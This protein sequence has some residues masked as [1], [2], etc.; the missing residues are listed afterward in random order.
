MH[1][2]FDFHMEHVQE[3]R[4]ESGLEGNGNALGPSNIGLSDQ[5]LL[6][7][8]RFGLEGLEEETRT[9]EQVSN[10]GVDRQMEE[11]VHPGANN[12]G[13]P[14]LVSSSSEN[15]PPPKGNRAA[16]LTP[17]GF[18]LLDRHHDK[19]ML[20][21]SVSWKRLM[22]INSNRI[23][24]RSSSWSKCFLLAPTT[25]SVSSPTLHHL[26]VRLNR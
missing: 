2:N 3:H 18:A 17:S 5:D 6:D 16:I 7:V 19:Q 9:N 12:I 21:L 26:K 20:I 24:M 22:C 8:E 14:P 11:L 13:L 23:R 1:A 10:T 25:S 4:E 15:I